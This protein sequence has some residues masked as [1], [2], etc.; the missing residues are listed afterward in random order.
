MADEATRNAL[1]VTLCTNL[2]V[3]SLLLEA[4]SRDS[5]S[6]DFPGPQSSVA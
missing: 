6:P 5:A 1:N 2:L 3:K 4:F